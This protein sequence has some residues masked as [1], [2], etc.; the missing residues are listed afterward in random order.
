MAI[1]YN[2]NC[3]KV[4]VQLTASDAQTPPNTHNDVVIDCY[5]KLLGTSD[6]GT[7]SMSGGKCKFNIDNLSNF[8]DFSSLTNDQVTGWVTSS[9][10]EASGSEYIENQKSLISSSIYDKENPV[11]EI[12]NLIN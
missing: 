11:V 5:W 9:L 10:I 2:W 12:K 3:K 6:K 4:E 1:D 7:I 8:T